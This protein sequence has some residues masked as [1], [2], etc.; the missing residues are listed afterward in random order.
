MRL[1]E[2]LSPG[3]KLFVLGVVFCSMSVLSLLWGWIH[4]RTDHFALGSLATG[5]VLVVA[6]SS[7]VRRE[8]GTSDD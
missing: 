2:R 4:G 3:R 7:L 8:R 6:G 5:V 1:G